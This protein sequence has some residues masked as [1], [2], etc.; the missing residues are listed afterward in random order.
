MGAPKATA[1]RYTHSGGDTSRLVTVMSITADGLTAVCADRKGFEARAPLFY[2]KA[3]GVLPQ[4]GENWFLSQANGTWMFDTFIGTSAGQFPVEYSQFF[5]GDTTNFH[6]LPDNTYINGA[7]HVD[8]KLYGSGGTLTVGDDLVMADGET[9][10]GYD[11]WH[12]LSLSNATAS[13]NG[14]SGMFYQLT[15]D[16][17]TELIWDI[18]LTSASGTVATLPS[19]YRPSVQQ[20]IRSGWYGG[21]PSS[22]T[23][24]FAPH[25][26]A[27]TNGTITLQSTASTSGISMFGHERIVLDAI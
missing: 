13:G 9:A 16:G 23:G 22:Y 7:L 21:G 14:V 12:S 26:L 5:S 17:D 8:D 1:S 6:V 10:S 25:L 3:K 24:S 15:L 2:Q 11:S 20:N 27:N 4:V 19:G 18:T